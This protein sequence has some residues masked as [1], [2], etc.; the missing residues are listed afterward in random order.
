[1]FF[2]PAPCISHNVLCHLFFLQ[3]SFWIV[4]HNSLQL[5]KVVEQAGMYPAFSSLLLF[6][7]IMHQIIIPLSAQH[8]PKLDL[9]YFIQNYFSHL[10][11][12]LQ[13]I[14]LWLFSASPSWRVSTVTGDSKETCSCSLIGLLSFLPFSQ[15]TPW[16][17]PN[18]PCS[19]P[20]HK[21]TPLSTQEFCDLHYQSSHVQANWVFH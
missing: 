17:L 2:V 15:I 1:M 21:C 19:Q 11:L 5:Q 8:Y 6:P 18:E 13:N 7:F 16:L 14:L 20:K 3:L 9:T 10:T 4:L 12:L